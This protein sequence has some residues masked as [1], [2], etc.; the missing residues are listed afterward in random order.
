[1]SIDCWFEERSAYQ[2]KIRG[3]QAEI[4]RLKTGR[5]LR[6]LEAEKSALRRKLQARIRDLRSQL[7]SRERE[8]KRMIGAWF[9]TWQTVKGEFEAEKEKL[10]GELDDMHERALKAERKADGLLGQLAQARHGIKELTGRIEELQGQNAKLAS[11]VKRDFENSSIPSSAQGPARKRVHNCRQDTRRTVGAQVGHP[12]HPR[13]KPSPTRRVRLPDPESFSADPDLYRTDEVVSR[14]V[15]SAK[16][17][18]EVTEYSARVWRRRSNGA[19]LHAPFPEGVRDEVSYDSSVKALAFGLIQGCCVSLGKTKAFLRE[20]SSGALNP[21]VGMLCGLSREFSQKSDLEKAEAMRALMSSPVM[22]ADFTGANV[23]GEAR[24]V[25]L[26]ASPA[27]SMLLARPGKGHAG[28]EATPLE[29]Y[30][31]CVTHDH[32]K[33]FYSYGTSHQ[34]CMQHNVRYLVGSVQDEPHLTWNKEMLSLVREMLHARNLKGSVGPEQAREFSRRWDEVLDLAERE[35]GQ[36]PPSK[37][38]RDGYNLFRRLGAYKESELRFLYDPRVPPDNSRCERLAR[39]FKR[40][41]H[42]AT[43]F[44]SFEGLSYACEAIGAIENMRCAGKDVFE[45]TAAIFA[46]PKPKPQAEAPR[47]LL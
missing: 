8:N 46:R 32:D 36:H 25:L 39:K 6:E 1:M 7:A 41:Q 40:K 38:C 47:D 24:Q 18:V 34:E 44:R 37:Y 22:G 30:C 10:L 2:L 31:G 11:Q 21:S 3:L 17:A 9:E 27:A 23:A 28:I 20:A 45:E 15:V 13:P 29:G 12:H 4:E 26:L 19:R 5:A 35:Y 14:I 16:V 42:Q 33:T 43:A